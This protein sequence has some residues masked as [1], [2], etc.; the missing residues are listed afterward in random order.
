MSRVLT[1]AERVE[2]IDLLNLSESA[3]E[4]TRIFN[5]RHPERAHPVN[6]STAIKLSNKFHDTGSVQDIR[7]RGRKSVLQ[8]IN[9][10]NN[11]LD[12]FRGDSHNS[13][14]KVSSELHHSTK[15]IRKVLKANHF[16]PYK[17]QKHQ[18]LLLIDYEARQN[19]CNNFIA[20]SQQDPGFVR[21]I[22]WTDECLFTL[23]G[24][25]NKQTYR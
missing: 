20:R 24:S 18:E 15:T 25:P 9:V 21:N 6:R 11:I 8:N 2:L 12:R 19:Y 4:A 7:G 14:R 13:I 17:F 1:T 16:K 10:V 22:L 23:D 5:R 3:A